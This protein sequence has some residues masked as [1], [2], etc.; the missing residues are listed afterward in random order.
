MSPG[1][2]MVYGIKYCA[3]VHERKVRVNVTRGAALKRPL[4]W[5]VV[6]LAVIVLGGC[7]SGDRDG[8]IPPVVSPT[9]AP[10]AWQRPQ[11]PIGQEAF[12]NVRVTGLM[13]FHQ[14]TVNAIAVS[15]N[16]TRLASVG[17]DD[18][19]VVWNLAN[20]QTLFTQ[21]D[22]DGRS[23]Y[24]GPDDETL[25][26][27]SRDGVV[28]V[29]AMDLAPPRQLEELAVF[30]GP[31]AGAGYVTQSPDRSLLAFGSRDSGVIRL[32][33]VPEGTL[34][35][36]IPAHSETV[37]HLAF[38]ADGARLVSVSIDGGVKV[39]TVAS[40]ELAHDL[41]LEG[42][43]P[44][45]AA[46]SADGS[47]LAVAYQSGVQLWDLASGDDVLFIEAAEYA[48]AN[49]LA[50]SP[51]GALLAGCGSQAIIGVWDAASGELLG[52]LPLPGQ[53][54]ATLAF[55]PD[56][57]LLLTLPQPGRD[58]YLWDITHITD[59]VPAEEKELRRRNRDNMGIFPGARFYDAVWS[60]D[61][62][63]IFALDE[64]GPIYVISAAG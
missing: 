24:F 59:D 22:T 13:R 16:G 34:L 60:E 64:L 40:R 38:S 18:M 57:L 56:G 45:R 39:W 49:A 11:A 37:Q 8:E 5:I 63:F 28:R 36:S 32:W 25:I 44:L 9:P 46:F 3:R 30:T 58:L 29:W 14:Q 47:R 43:L 21:G 33:R 2:Q 35:D 4:I 6:A 27:I 10:V 17:A 19:T 61:G 42:R 20:G 55:S 1:V 48:A 53:V 51:D 31:E 54:C 50:F 26:T 15:A 41:T 62:R 7:S 52:G 12:A 23:V